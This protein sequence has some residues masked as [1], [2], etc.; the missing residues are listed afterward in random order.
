MKLFFGALPLLASLSL[1]FLSIPASH[2][3][4]RDGHYTTCKL[5]EPL[6][7]NAT[8]AAVQDLLPPGVDDLANVCSLADYVRFKYRWSSALHFADGIA[9]I[10]MG[11]QTGVAGAINNYTTQ[12]L[13]YSSGSPTQYNLTEALLFLAHF[14]GDIHQPLHCGHVGDRGG[15]LI[16]VH[17]YR[18]K[19]NLHHVVLRVW[20]TSIIG[21]EEYY[22]YDKSVDGLIDTIQTNITVSS[23][24]TT[25]IDGSFTMTEHLKY[26]YGRHAA[27]A[28]SHHALTYACE[29]VKAACDWAYPGVHE[30]SY[31]GDDYFY[32]RYPVV[33]KR[34]AMGGIRLAAILNRIFGS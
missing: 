7:S 6:F 12:I 34:L 26:Q 19:T 13:A 23:T 4:G 15:N 18:R 11:F 20:D 33:N 31:L 30:G 27:M 2:A 16:D 32:S 1:L 28:A 22:F 5:A 3:W 29:S 8:N 25:T 10:G 24:I 14:V 21:S 17:W 9:M